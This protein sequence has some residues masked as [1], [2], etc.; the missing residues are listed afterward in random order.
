M[1]RV[2]EDAAGKITALSQAEV[3]VRLGYKK[4]SKQVFIAKYENGYVY[5]PEPDFLHKWAK[6][7]ARDYMEVVVQLVR[8]KYAIGKNG[9]ARRWSEVDQLKWELID[10]LF[11]ARAAEVGQVSGLE[12]HQLKAMAEIIGKEEVLDMEGLALWER[13][14]PGLKSCWIIAQQFIDTEAT[15]F[16]DAVAENL[17]RGVRYTFFLPEELIGATRDFQ[18]LKD[19]LVEDSGITRKTVDELLVGVPLNK[20]MRGLLQHDYVIANPLRWVEAVG[21]LCVRKPTMLG[22]SAVRPRPTYAMRMTGEQLEH[23]VLEIRHHLECVEN[24]QAEVSDEFRNIVKSRLS[25][26]L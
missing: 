5:D 13:H 20:H 8:D 25:H 17:R 24:P 6:L 10:R 3:A 22:H 19:R 7:F 1:K 9:D 4:E 18:H 23:L 11:I 12:L 2:R 21:F 26:I 15:F 16:A 14:F